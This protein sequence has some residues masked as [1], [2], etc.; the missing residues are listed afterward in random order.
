MRTQGIYY[1]TNRNHLGDDRWH[2]KGY[3]T[4]FSQDGREN[5]RFGKLSLTA[6]KTEIKRCLA[7][8]LT[9]MG[10]G[11]GEKLA[12]HFAKQAESAT[13]EAF[14]ENIVKEVADMKQDLSRFGSQRFF[15]ELKD[16]MMKSSD[17]LVFIHGYNVSWQNAVGSALALQTMLNR[18]GAGDSTQKV[19]V[20][21]F[22]WPSEGSM[23]PFRAYKA[24]RADARDS[25][26]A[27]GRAILK[28]RDF[29]VKIREEAKDREKDLC[30]QDIHILCHSMGNY[31][32]ENALQ[33]IQQFSPGPVLPHIFEHIFLCSPDVDDTVLEPGAPMERLDELARSVSVYYNREDKALLIS[34]VTKANPTRLGTSGAARPFALHN[35]I[36]QIDCTPIVTGLTEHSYFLNGSVNTDIK[37][38]IDGMR[39][40]AGERDRAS[41]GE[42]PNVWRMKAV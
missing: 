42:L 8:R 39:Q 41:T 21:L 1:A 9:G 32:L 22:S 23:F 11:D 12:A 5:L 13:I 19:M 38:S 10:K 40:D 24:D 4:D 15:G 25:G 28:L 18:P 20:V 30:N 26:F 29:L 6:D 35:K 36:H 31:V 2:P 17:V 16:E 33:R 3:G 34:D 37:H 7:S 14:E 27:V